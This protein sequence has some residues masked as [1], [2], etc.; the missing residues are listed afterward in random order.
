M[1]FIFIRANKKN[2]KEK[3]LIGLRE[4]VQQEGEALDVALK[5]LLGVPSGN[6]SLKALLVAHHL[7]ALGGGRAASAMAMTTLAR[8]SSSWMAAKKRPNLGRSRPI[9]R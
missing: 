4:A 1:L 3:S 6:H 7:G 5:G 9:R 2:K 8:V